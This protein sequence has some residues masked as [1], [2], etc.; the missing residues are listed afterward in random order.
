VRRPGRVAADGDIA[1]MNATVRTALAT[2]AFCQTRPAT[3]TTRVKTLLG[4]PEDVPVCAPCRYERLVWL[5]RDL[6]AY[7]A[8]LRAQMRAAGQLVEDE[9]LEDETEE[10]E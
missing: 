5:D 6:K 10:E 9:G 8:G 3:D 2:C 4:E 1:A 7:C